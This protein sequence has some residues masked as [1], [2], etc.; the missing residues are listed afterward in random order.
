MKFLR[1]I[2]LV[3]MLFFSFNAI[4]QTGSSASGVNDSGPPAGTRHHHHARQSEGHVVSRPS[5]QALPKDH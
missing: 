3:G 4:A 5:V 2:P 1:I